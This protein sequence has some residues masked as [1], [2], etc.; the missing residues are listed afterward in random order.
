MAKRKPKEQPPSFEAA[1][2][3]SRDGLSRYSHAA[4]KMKQFDPRGFFD[5]PP[6]QQVLR[7]TT[8]TELIL[9]H[10]GELAKL[11]QKLNG[12]LPPERRAKL[13]SDREIKM[14]FLKKLSAEYQ[15]LIS[16]GA[17]DVC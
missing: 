16:K 4:A 2:G 13:E 15:E 9:R 14:R 1:P 10:R 17:R 6:A 12:S 8:V 3:Y 11:V 7:Q 5:R